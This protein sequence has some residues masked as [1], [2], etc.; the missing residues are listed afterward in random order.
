MLG[1]ASS[2]PFFVWAAYVDA[3]VL[4]DGTRWTHLIPLFGL[5]RRTL[6]PVVRWM[7]GTPHVIAAVLDYL[8]VLGVWVAIVLVLYLFWKRRYW[9]RQSA[10]VV[11]AL[12][13]F[14][15]AI[16]FVSNPKVWAE[17]YAF[18]RLV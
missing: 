10:P 13:T 1:L 11:V 9:Q 15:L 6:R 18:G 2:V 7:G 8:A 3:H 17:A 5:Y 14:T 16:A 4:A 12:A